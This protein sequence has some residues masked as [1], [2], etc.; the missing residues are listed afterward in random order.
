M[1]SFKYQYILILTTIIFSIKS[2]KNNKI[3]ELSGNEVDDTIQN[4]IDYSLKLFII[5]YVESCPYCHHA[6]KVLKEKIIHNYNE[7]D[8][9]KFMIV[10]LDLRENIWLAARFNITKI[11][12]MI[13]IEE[14]KMY[15]FDKQ[16]EEE[17]VTKF[18]DE[19]KNYEDSLIIPGRVNFF[20]KFSLIN[21]EVTGKILYSFK[22]LTD[23]FGI[24][25]YW[26]SNLTIL[27]LAIFLFG[28]FYIELKIIRFICQ[29]FGFG[30]KRKENNTKVEENDSNKKKKENNKE[31][32]KEDK[33]N[34]K[35]IENESDKKEKG[36]EKKKKE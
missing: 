20:D 18:I 32:K 11:P 33:K 3:L 10:N 12:Y 16:F 13:L 17:T 23:K 8:N 31:G 14:K 36:K 28:T 21:N 34:S 22:K 29:L 25:I 35:N 7:E 5:F 19:E 30:K 26:N 24:K 15:Y 2:S 9:I 27:S 6:L 4:A 1:L